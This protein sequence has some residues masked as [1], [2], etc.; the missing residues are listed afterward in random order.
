MPSLKERA[1]QDADIREFYVH[2]HRFGLSTEALRLLNTA[3]AKKRPNY[4][5]SN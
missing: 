1:L 4:A 5:L 3:I 2:V